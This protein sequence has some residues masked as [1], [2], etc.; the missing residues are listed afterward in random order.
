MTYQL[1]I[2]HD[3]TGLITRLKLARP[4]NDC[5]PHNFSAQWCHN[6]IHPLENLFFLFFN[7]DER[8]IISPSRL[9]K[10]RIF[11][12]NAILARKQDFTRH[13]SSLSNEIM[14][15]PATNSSNTQPSNRSFIESFPSVWKISEYSSIAVSQSST[16]HNR[17]FHNF[18]NRFWKISTPNHTLFSITSR[19]GL[20]PTIKIY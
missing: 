13:F 6:V 9:R 14:E 15:T 19:S 7:Q 17:R 11:P 18:S 16:D 2:I 3:E 1:Y 4:L 10:L 5:Y 8:S 20:R 12:I